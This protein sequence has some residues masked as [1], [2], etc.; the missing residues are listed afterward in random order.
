MSDA[1]G[2]DPG[3]GLYDGV[4]LPVL[5]RQMVA[6]ARRS[7][8]PVSVVCFEL[9]GPDG[10]A[11]NADALGAAAAIVLRTLRESDASFRTGDHRITALLEDTGE[12]GALWAARRGVA[13]AG[14]R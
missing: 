4:H 5:A 11:P 2:T 3:T 7:L 9:E 1:A 13:P 8:R 10:G 12:D 6:S 14:D